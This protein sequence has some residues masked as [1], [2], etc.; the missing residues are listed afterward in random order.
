MAMPSGPPKQIACCDDGKIFL[1]LPGV[2]PR[3]PAHFQSLS[4]LSY[5]SYKQMKLRFSV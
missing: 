2:E 5:Y 4:Y 3:S 1:Y